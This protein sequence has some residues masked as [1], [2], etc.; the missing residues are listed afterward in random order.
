M[1]I[2]SDLVCQK[3]NLYSDNCIPFYSHLIILFI[4]NCLVGITYSI[5]YA[6][7]FNIAINI[8]II[9]ITIIIMLL[10]VTFSEVKLR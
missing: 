9:I 10:L 6:N 7:N 4:L 3:D 1:A 2:V 8:E 5:N